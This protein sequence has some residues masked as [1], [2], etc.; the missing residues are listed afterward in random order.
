M[1]KPKEEEKKIRK[2][3]HAH[4]NMKNVTNDTF[5]SMGEKERAKMTKKSKNTTKKTRQ[6]VLVVEVDIDKTQTSLTE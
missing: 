1:G 3:T 6:D 2:S 5:V 4:F